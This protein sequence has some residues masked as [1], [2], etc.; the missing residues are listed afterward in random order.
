MS[1]CSHNFNI[2]T[3]YVFVMAAGIAQSVYRLA[4]GW[5]GRGLNPGASKIFHISPYPPPG[6][7][8]LM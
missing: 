5:K 4:T 2:I 6:Q 1:F 3:F 8:N 7:H